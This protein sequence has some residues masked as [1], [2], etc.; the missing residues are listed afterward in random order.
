MKP[1]PILLALTLAACA[2][3][4]DLAQLRR[5]QPTGSGFSETLAREYRSFALQRSANGSWPAAEHFAGKGLAALAGAAP[6]PEPVDPGLPDVLRATLEQ[7]RAR[8]VQDLAEGAAE[9]YP[10]FTAVALARFDCWAE[11]AQ[12]WPEGG[13]AQRCRREFEENLLTLEEARARLKGNS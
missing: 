6:E 4:G 8:L 10:A 13:E 9:R 3:T 12:A 11:R 5:Q 1:T 2:G 7:S